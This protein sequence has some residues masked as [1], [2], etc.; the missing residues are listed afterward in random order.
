M[1]GKKSMEALQNHHKGFN[2]AESVILPFCDELGLPKQT[3]ARAMEGFGGGMGGYELTCGA[4]FIASLKVSQCS[5]EEGP[6]SKLNTYAVC[7][8]LV[9]DFRKECGSDCCPVIKG[10][11]T[12]KMLATCD[13][14][15]MTGAALADKIPLKK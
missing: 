5:L 6:V 14:C 15:I 4:V 3:M 13:K 9:E 12:G 1:A 10:I 11:K 2:C 7:K 8:Q